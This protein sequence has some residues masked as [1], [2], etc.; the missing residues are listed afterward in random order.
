MLLRPTVNTHIPEVCIT[1]Q[2][3]GPSKHKPPTL[4]LTVSPVAVAVCTAYLLD[5]LLLTEPQQQQPPLLLL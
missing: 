2:M 1:S 3:Q 5:L 4:L